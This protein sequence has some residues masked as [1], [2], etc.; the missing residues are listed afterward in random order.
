MGLICGLGGSIGLLRNGAIYGSKDL[1]SICLAEVG[2]AHN[3]VPVGLRHHAFPY[4]VHHGTGHLSCVPLPPLRILGTQVRAR[5][6]QESCKERGGQK[7][8][9]RIVLIASWRDGL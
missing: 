4:Y 9:E 5:R 2:T 6:C 8:E 7:D 3:L 1:E